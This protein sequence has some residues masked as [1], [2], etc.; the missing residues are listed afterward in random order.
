MSVLGTFTVEALNFAR[1]D[2]FSA[3]FGDRV[4][5]RNLVIFVTDGVSFDSVDIGNGLTTLDLAADF[6]HG[7]ADVS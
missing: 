3:A 4:D 6:L 5:A 2:G 1:T 7:V